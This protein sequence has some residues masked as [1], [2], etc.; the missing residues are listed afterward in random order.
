METHK[1]GERIL[2]L[3]ASFAGLYTAVFL[4]GYLRRAR[5]PRPSIT[6]LD[7]NNFLLFTTFLPEVV[8]NSLN[9]L[10]ITPSVRRILGGR[11]I[12]FR[13]TTV[14]EIDLAGK[15]VKT[16][17]GTLDYDILILGLGGLTNYYGNQACEQYGFPCKT[18]PDALR[19]RN[20]IINCL[21]R[22]NATSDPQEKRRL[23][24]FLQAGAGCT[25]L[26]LMTEL[27][28]FLHSAVGRIYR[29]IDF[30]RD[31]RLILA[32][33]LER[34]LITLPVHLSRKAHAKLEH[35]G[36]E[37]RLNTFVTGAGPGW[38]ELNKTER[39]ETETLIWVAG[40]R[41]SPLVA[42][43]PVEH[44]KLGRVVVDRHLNVPGHP[45]VYALGDNALCPGED[46]QPLGQTAQVAV[47]QAPLLARN[48][49][50]LREGRPA[51]PFKYHYRGDLVSMGSMDAVCCPYGFHLFGLPAWFLFRVVYFSKLPTVHARL[52]VATD[53]FVKGLTGPNV[54]RLETDGINE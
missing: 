37:M 39:I 4:D 46:G 38:V 52:R 17:A 53:W 1:G 22:A 14:E 43:L 19:L 5:G 54:S 45:G 15:R 26:E 35:I 16:A 34:V 32:E 44:D 36:I 27:A 8:S 10:S 48:L 23:L 47:Q 21:E 7:R 51:Q 20:H 31:V 33:G 29:N 3:G 12:D 28:E 40:V 2:I 6:L 9:P 49:L 24:T 25:G 13:Q 41:G 30:K 50:A 18:M 42:G 11:A